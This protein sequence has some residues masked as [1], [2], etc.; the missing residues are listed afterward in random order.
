MYC[1]KQMML[2][3]KIQEMSF[4]ATEL[5]LYLDTRPCDQD[6]LNDYNC[7]V[8]VVKKYRNE[9]EAEFGS[10]MALGFHGDKEW[11]WICDPWPWEM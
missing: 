7:A 11:T 4:V 9:Y 8:D 10:I 1:E 2:L 5:H 3:R 6:A